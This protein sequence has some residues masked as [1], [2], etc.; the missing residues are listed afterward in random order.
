MLAF[1]THC[2]IQ[3]TYSTKMNLSVV[4]TRENRGNAG[5]GFK[6]FINDQATVRDSA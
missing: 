4:V 6:C 3:F 5:N 2:S 1:S